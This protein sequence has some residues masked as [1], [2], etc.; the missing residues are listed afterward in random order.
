MNSNIRGSSS[1]S[2]GEV[3][4]G[5][6]DDIGALKQQMNE[7]GGILN[8]IQQQLQVFLKMKYFRIFL[9]HNY[10]FRVIAFNTCFWILF[11]L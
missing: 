10:V 8:N 11:C 2:G 3:G 7:I 5:S 6:S 1:G 4:G 9:L